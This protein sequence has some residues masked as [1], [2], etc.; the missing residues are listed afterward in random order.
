MA[1]NRVIGKDNRIPWHLPRELQMFKSLTMGHHLIMGRKTYE[2]LNRL[3]PG[4]TSIIVTRNENYK[5]PGAIVVNTLQAALAACTHDVEIFI[6]GGAELFKEALPLADRIYL[7]T[8]QAEIE[9]DT[10]MPDLDLRGWHQISKQKFKA[11]EKN[12]YDYIFSVHHK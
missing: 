4:R 5:V 8:L 12:L 9:G 6:I 2:S 7:T 11:D 1:K 3:L 10:Y